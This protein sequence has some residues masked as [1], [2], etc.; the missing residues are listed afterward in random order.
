MPQTT[1]LEQGGD[2]A[3]S[4]DGLDLVSPVIDLV[5]P[6]AK[7]LAHISAQILSEQKNQGAIKVSSAA[8]KMFVQRQ[9]LSE[10]SESGKPTY[11]LLA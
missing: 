5:S 4:T 6:E 3:I 11:G 1:R 10:V 8:I 9:Q 2:D 7:A